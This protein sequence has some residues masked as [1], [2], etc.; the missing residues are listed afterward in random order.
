MRLEFLDLTLRFDTIPA[1]T[2]VTA[3]LNGQVVGVLGANGSGKTS[4]LK[5]LAGLTAP[6][7]GRALIDGEEVHPGPKSWISYLPQETNFFPFLQ[8]PGRTLSLTMAFRGVQDPNA[9]HKILEALGLEEEERSAEGFSG[10]MKQKLRI[11]TA[12]VH[13]PRL[14]VMDEPMTGLDTRERFR[15]LRLI[16]RL[17]GRVSVV[18]STHNPHDAAAVCDA[19]LILGRGRAVAVGVPDDLAQEA[20]GSVYEIEV[21]SLSLPSDEAYE[22]IQAH[23]EDGRFRLRVLGTPPPGAREVS[24]TFEDAYLLLTARKVGS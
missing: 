15:V 1:L 21:S 16:E 13:A 2:Q 7:S 18:F 9:P 12:L 6:T 5:I 17:R 22:V 11:A 4:L 8:H 3:T 14:L 24:P 10:G 19:V 23:R 20:K